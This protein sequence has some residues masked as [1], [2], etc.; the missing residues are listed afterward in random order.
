MAS[1]Q[2]AVNKNVQ[3]YAAGGE[4]GTAPQPPATPLI[5]TPPQDM[6]LGGGLPQRGTIPISSVNPADIN[7]SNRMFRGQGSRSTVYPY[8]NR[9]AI[10]SATSSVQ[11]VTAAVSPATAALLIQVNGAPTPVQD[12]LDLIAGSGINLTPDAT[13]GITIDSTSAGDGLIHGDAI[14]EIDPA[15]VLMRD[16]FIN[17]SPAAGSLTSFTSEIPWFAIGVGSSGF[18]GGGPLPQEGLLLLDNNGTANN[19]SAILPQI[20][21]Q[22]AQFGWPLLDYPG[23][24]IIW[25]FEVGR[26]AA[27]SPG[28]SFSWAQVSTYIGLANYPGLSGNLVITNSPRPPYFLGLRYDTDTTSPAISD[29]QFVFEYVMNPTATPATRINTQGTV[30]ATGIHPTEG[31]S[32]RLEIS[33][34]I[35]GSVTLLLTDGTTSFTTTMAVTQ[36]STNNAPGITSSNTGMIIASYTVSPPWAAGSIFT[37]AGGSKADINGTWTMRPGT[38]NPSV[39]VW[40]FTSASSGS[41]TGAITTV[42]PAMVPFVSFGNDSQATPVAGT[43][44][45]GIDYFGFVWNPGVGGGTGTPNSL[46]ARYF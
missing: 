30:V 14:W 27:V 5:S 24:K 32:Y 34:T 23:W 36:F 21:A 19:M 31:N 12:I 43:K 35:A 29:T 11:A 3:R 20:Q 37:I 39:A 46:L 8:P 10:S 17:T 22:P 44:G 33:C 7:D 1:I 42:Y 4:P 13:G 38:I 41:D 28:A 15:Y 9:P 26:L 45:L 16:D 2:D 6:P 40:Y 18:V 25:E